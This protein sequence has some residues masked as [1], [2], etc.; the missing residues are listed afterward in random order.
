MAWMDVFDLNAITI[1]HF[2]IM[3][4]IVLRN[5]KYLG[6]RTLFILL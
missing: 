1:R 4:S 3:I 5:E 6:R 2:A